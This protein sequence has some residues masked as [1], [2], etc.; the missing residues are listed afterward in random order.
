MIFIIMHENLKGYIKLFLEAGI[1]VS[2]NMSLASR[3]SAKY[4][5][6]KNYPFHKNYPMEENQDELNE[7]N[8]EEV[9][10][11]KEFIHK[12]LNPKIW[13]SNKELKP[14]V[15]KKLLQISLEFYKYLNI[16]IPIKGIRLI[17]SNANYNWSN[18]SDIDIHF[19]FDFK[20]LSPDYDFVED[21]FITK[22][23]YWNLN[24]NIKIKGLPVE[25]YCNSLEDKLQ[26]AGMYFRTIV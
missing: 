24:N 13:N 17:G 23:N 1:G 5:N 15:R 14:E 6:N 20:D 22:K 25:L 26:S 4:R 3:H 7:I 21:F 16:K 11:P 12:E 18:Q 8:P 10:I 9:S 19:F 2:R